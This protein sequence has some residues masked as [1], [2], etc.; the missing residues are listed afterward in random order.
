M[1]VYGLPA[2]R[3]RQC[4]RAIFTDISVILL[5]TIAQ[6]RLQKGEGCRSNEPDLRGHFDPSQGEGALAAISA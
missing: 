6:N 5:V 3:H 1:A 2:V 4:S